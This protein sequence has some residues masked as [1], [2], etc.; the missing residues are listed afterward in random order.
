MLC[1]PL[2]IK[3]DVHVVVGAVQDRRARVLALEALLAL[4]VVEGEAQACHRVGLVVGTKNLGVF[5][6]VHKREMIMLHLKL[7]SI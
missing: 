7:I 5:K 1:Q 4:S 3:E 2:R 6:V